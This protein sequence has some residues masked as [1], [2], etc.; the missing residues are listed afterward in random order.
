M[1]V[2]RAYTIPLLAGMLLTPVFAQQGGRPQQQKQGRGNAQPK[3][4]PQL[5]NRLAQMTPEEREKA[6]SRLPPA[7]RENLERQIR[8]FQQLPPAAQERRLDRA[9]RL[10][11][12][13]PQQQNQVRRSAN[14]LRNL[15][16]DRRMAINQE[17]RHM[18]VMPDDER[19][20]YMNTEEFRNRFSPDE[21]R[22]VGNLAKILPPGE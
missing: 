21:Q 5:L 14:Q 20:A 10:N 3:P 22:I 19:Q 8:N 18:S 9:E 6:L 11:S 12:L 15:P 4:G 17:L 7:Q 16:E 2:L 1:P 13:P